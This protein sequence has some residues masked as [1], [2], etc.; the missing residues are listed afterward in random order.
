MSKQASNIFAISHIDFYT[1]S[2]LLRNHVDFCIGVSDIEKFTQK[3]VT[4]NIVFFQKW[5]LL[6]KIKDKLGTPFVAI[7][8]MPADVA[9]MY[10]IKVL[11]NPKSSGL[12][13]LDLA[14]LTKRKAGVLYIPLFNTDEAMIQKQIDTIKANQIMSHILTYTYAVPRSASED[15]WRDFLNWLTSKLSTKQFG[16]KYRNNWPKAGAAFNLLYAFM[17]SPKGEKYIEVFTD[18]FIHK[19]PKTIATQA[20]IVNFE[21]NYFERK[22]IS[23]K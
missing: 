8:C 2:R 21:I 10:G 12:P 20:G 6:F 18:I 7:V 4:A 23:L 15:V 16:D 5:N 19:K 9:E 1:A 13:S 3:L 14:A 17:D 11:D 22:W